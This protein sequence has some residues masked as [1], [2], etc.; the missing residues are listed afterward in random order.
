[1]N[2]DFI[3]PTDSKLH[4]INDEEL[5]DL[6]APL[7]I[8]DRIRILAYGSGFEDSFNDLNEELFLIAKRV[9]AIRL[10]GA[11]IPSELVPSTWHLPENSFDGV[12]K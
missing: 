11:E 4:I 9:S 7:S 6:I 5:N 10:A 1:M 12:K 2:E 8:E 3:K